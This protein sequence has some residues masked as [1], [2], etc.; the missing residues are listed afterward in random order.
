MMNDIQKSFRESKS[1][2]DEIQQ[3]S[4]REGNLAS[5]L[6]IKKKIID[7]SLIVLSAIL[8]SSAFPPLNWNF[9]AWFSVCP[10]FMLIR[11]QPPLVSF[12]RAYLWG[13]IW[14]IISFF[15]L[16]EI[17]VFVPFLIALI[18]AFFPALWA[19]FASFAERYI[20]YPSDILLNG[21]S[22]IDSYRKENQH[23]LIWN[24][25]DIHFALILAAFWTFLEWIRSWIFTGL[26][27]NLAAT[28]Q[29]QNPVIIQIADI[30]GAYGISF[31]IIMLNV[32]IGITAGKL[33]TMI[34]EGRF[35]RPVALYFSIIIIMLCIGYGSRA[36]MRQ[37]PLQKEFKQ[38]KV[39]VI[40]PDIPQCRIPTEEQA[41]FAARKNIELID[42]AISSKPDIIVLPETSVPLPFQ[43]RHPLAVEFKNQ[44]LKY[45][46]NYNI[47][48]LLGTIYY[49]IIPFAKEE[50]QEPTIHNSAI[51]IEPDG[52]IIDKYHKIHLVPFGEYTPFSKYLSALKKYF[53][54]G[55]DL[56]PGK[57]YTIFNIPG[58]I[59][60]GVNICYEDIFPQISRK[61]SKK[62]AEIIFVLTN[63]AWYP[64][65]SEPEQ[66]FA[67]SVFRAVENRRTIIRCGNNNYSSVL[68]PTGIVQESISQK[69]D[70]KTGKMI[71]APEKKTRGYAVFNIQVPL[72]SSKTFYTQ[73]GD[74]FILVSAFFLLLAAIEM[75]WKWHQTRKEIIESF[76]Q[77]SK[78]S[79]EKTKS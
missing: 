34:A 47:Y 75:L 55:R 22:S 74:I 32:S 45:A 79:D 8:Y 4:S 12:I 24:I 26:P 33:N 76:N 53:G 5:Q 61:L 6:S 73:Y 1:F 18:L 16:R 42:L 40:Q 65:S 68:S 70:P 71:P 17:E 19:S 60:A 78:T 52:K 29:W 10:L 49:E 39:A 11:R 3:K 57:D 35:K 54:M 14:A 46:Q 13:Y 2:Q 56:T 64:R 69:H 20:Y 28:S 66:H 63:D 23:S 30:T 62:G 9:M 37:H 25:K 21:F 48:F 7:Y 50:E 77:Q 58:G 43:S 15:W 27:W 59:S 38:V 31:M 72:H 36:I 51:L 67:H 44:I 41:D